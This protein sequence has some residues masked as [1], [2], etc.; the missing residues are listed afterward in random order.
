[1]AVR[2]VL[3]PRGEGSTRDDRAVRASSRFCSI[4]PPDFAG[5]AFVI[6][7]TTRGGPRPR[8][9]FCSSRRG[10]A[11]SAWSQ[12]VQRSGHP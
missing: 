10:P 6:V 8:G 12:F 4:R 3:F 2:P 5:W 7:W 11:C 1:M 9:T